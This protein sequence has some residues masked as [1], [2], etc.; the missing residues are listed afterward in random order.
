MYTK[1]DIYDFSTRVTITSKRRLVGVVELAD[2]MQKRH[3]QTQYL[4]KDV[5][6]IMRLCS[7][8][9]FINI[10]KTYLKS[11]SP[12]SNALAQSL[13]P[14]CQSIMSDCFVM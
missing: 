10:G 12:R 11:S 1:L 2:I 4:S 9:Q 6:I 7:K 3:S 8:I 5:V 14:I 13:I